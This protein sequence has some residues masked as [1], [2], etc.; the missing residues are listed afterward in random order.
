NPGSLL[1]LKRG[2]TTETLPEMNQ[3]FLDEVELADVEEIVFQ[4]D[5]DG[6]S[7]Q[8]WLLKPIKFDAN[9]KY[10]MILEIHGGPHLMYGNTFLD[11]KST[12]LNSSHV[13][14]SYA[15]FC[16]KKKIKIKNT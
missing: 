15:V 6:E 11:R 14:I 4:S 3:S 10:P 13:S 1:S 7:I 9:K 16:L 8:G 5:D 2:G 12:R